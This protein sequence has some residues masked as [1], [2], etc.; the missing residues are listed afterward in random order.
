MTCGPP[1]NVRPGCEVLRESRAGMVNAVM[2]TVALSAV[3]ILN[4]RLFV[5]VFETA[6]SGARAPGSEV[7]LAVALAAVSCSVCTPHGLN[8]GP[9]HGYLLVGS[10]LNA[11]NKG[12]LLSSGAREC[13]PHVPMVR[14]KIHLAHRQE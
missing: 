12:P 6:G 4:H 1:E 2:I 9:E 10:L 11:D 3:F 13:I 14:E 7:L 8:G 5:S